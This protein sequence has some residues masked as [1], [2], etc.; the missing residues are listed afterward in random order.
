MTSALIMFMWVSVQLEV[1]WQERCDAAL[2]EQKF[3]MEEAIT[4]LH[5]Q[6]PCPEGTNGQ[7]FV[8][9]SIRSL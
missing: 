2:N 1:E 7:I 4:Q 9:P 6:V 3:K 5:I 8:Y